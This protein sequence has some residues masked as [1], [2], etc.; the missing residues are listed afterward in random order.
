MVELEPVTAGILLLI[1]WMP[2]VQLN[3]PIAETPGL[4]WMENDEGRILK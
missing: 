4:W 3:P 2:A 1:L